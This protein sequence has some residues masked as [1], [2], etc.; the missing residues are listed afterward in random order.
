[1]MRMTS[2]KCRPVCHLEA[3]STGTLKQF[4]LPVQADNGEQTPFP[5]LVA[6][7]ALHVSVM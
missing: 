7:Y 3:V 2:I 5:R 1:M 4:R 6:L